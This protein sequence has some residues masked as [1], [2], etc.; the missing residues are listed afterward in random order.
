MRAKNKV[1][2][3]AAATLALVM[4]G[5]SPAHAAGSVTNPTAVKCSDVNVPG[6]GYVP[7]YIQIEASGDVN[8]V[9]I[10]GQAIASRGGTFRTYFSSA[11]AGQIKVTS[12]TTASRVSLRTKCWYPQ[13]IG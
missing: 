12:A 8:G 13:Q 7:R 1:I 9:Y 2:G 5:T 10:Y 11:K 4:L 6:Y 3:T